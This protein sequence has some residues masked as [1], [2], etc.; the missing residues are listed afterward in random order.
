MG[1][2]FRFPNVTKRTSHANTNGRKRNA[3]AQRYDQFQLGVSQKNSNA[4]TT[5]RRLSHAGL[6]R[7]KT[8]YAGRTSNAT[9]RDFRASIDPICLPPTIGDNEVPL[10][11]HELN[12]RGG[13]R[14]SLRASS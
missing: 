12:G 5:M 10:L 1:R 3:A 13:E 2:G 14:C 8:P 7:S 4:A 9:N 11:G 6:P